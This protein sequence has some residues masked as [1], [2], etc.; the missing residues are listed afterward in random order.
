MNKSILLILVST[1]LLSSCF[2]E[3]FDH[4]ERQNSIPKHSM[5][6]KGSLSGLLIILPDKSELSKLIEKISKAKDRVW[7]ETY[8]WTEKGTLDQV[9]KLGK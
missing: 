3:Y 7:I 1:L 2:D 4:F 6:E 8:T 5:I 9:I